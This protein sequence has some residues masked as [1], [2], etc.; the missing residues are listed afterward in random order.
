MKRHGGI[1]QETGEFLVFEKVL[2]PGCCFAPVHEALTGY[3]HR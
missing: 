1:F 2:D 3:L